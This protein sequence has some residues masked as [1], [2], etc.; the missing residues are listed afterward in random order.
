MTKVKLILIIS[1]YVFYELIILLKVFVLL[2]LKIKNVGGFMVRKLGLVLFICS[3]VFA[4]SCNGKHGASQKTNWESK[5]DI[6]L[7]I[8]TAAPILFNG[9]E[10]PNG[11][12]EPDENGII[13]LVNGRL[14]LKRVELPAY[15]RDVKLT[16]KARLV[17]TGDDYDRSGSIFILSDKK[18]G[19]SPI[20]IAKDGKYPVMEG[21]LNKYPGIISVENYEPCVEAMRFMTPFGVGYYSDNPKLKPPSHVT[22]W[23]KDVKWETDISHLYS[24]LEG[25]A[26]IGVWIDTWVPGGDTKRPRGGWELDLTLEAKESKENKPRTEWKVAPLMNTVSYI[27]QKYPD[28]FAQIKTGVD[29]TIDLSK[30]KEAKLYYTVTGHGGN[31]G[32]EFHKKKNIISLGK[33]KIKEWFPCKDSCKHVRKWNP[34]SLTWKDGTSSSDLPRSNWCPSEMVPPEIIPLDEN[35]LNPNS[36]FNFTIKNTTKS[37]GDNLNFWLV[38]AYLVYR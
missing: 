18:K 20:D 4:L 17:S 27:G 19:V 22:A 16:L 9:A 1:T 8:F 13:R 2:D 21:E 35:D 7:D 28:V 34:A 26:Y 5:G 6:T 38:S 31:N 15:E 24:L 11:Y 33:K 3:M 23:E 14:I 25:G 32:D 12:N 10:V 37:S 36:T 29:V 30:M